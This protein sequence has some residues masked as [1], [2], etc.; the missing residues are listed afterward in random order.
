MKELFAQR[1]YTG[2]NCARLVAVVI[3]VHACVVVYGQSTVAGNR[4]RWEK[5]VYED[6]KTAIQETTAELARNANNAIALRMRSSAYYRNFEPEKAGN[7]CGTG[8]ECQQCDRIE[9]A[10][11]RILQEF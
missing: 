10:L 7:D 3:A 1:Y 4:V 8:E 9:N 2:G 6:P 5:L 11:I